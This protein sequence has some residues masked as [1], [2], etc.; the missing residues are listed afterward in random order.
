WNSDFDC[1]KV[2]IHFKS[3]VQSLTGVAA[4]KLQAYQLTNSQWQLAEDLMSI[5][6][7]S[8]LQIFEDGTK[9]FSTSEVPLIVDAVPIL[10]NIGDS[11]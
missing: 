7:V 5:L 10:E 1:L 9:L 6:E 3:I 8:W 4:N 11:L 2:H